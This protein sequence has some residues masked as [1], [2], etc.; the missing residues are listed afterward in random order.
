MKKTVSG[1]QADC[2]QEQAESGTRGH[3]DHHHAG[4]PWQRRR[5]EPEIE[6]G[7][8]GGEAERADQ[9]A[10]GHER[11]RPAADRASRLAGVASSD[12]SVP[13]QRSLAMAIV[14]PNTPARTL[15]WTALPMAK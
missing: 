7:Q 5:G 13:N 14:M 6:Q 9:H 3:R 15:T 4:Q 12:G 8:P 2:P 10:V 1:T 11:E